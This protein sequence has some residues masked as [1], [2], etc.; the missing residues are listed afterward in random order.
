[1][2]LNPERD[3]ADPEYIKFL[4]RYEDGALDA[5]A[6]A[7]ATLE[8]GPPEGRNSIARIVAHEWQADGFIREGKIVEVEPVAVIGD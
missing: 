1:M 4:A 6:V 5:F 7:R 8:Q 3:L 2:T